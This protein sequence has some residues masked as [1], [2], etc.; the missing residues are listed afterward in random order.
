MLAR[1]PGPGLLG[2]WFTEQGLWKLRQQ[3]T[4]I[5]AESQEDHLEG[6]GGEWPLLA[7]SLQADFQRH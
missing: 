7:G 3:K 2:L 5:K 1:G 4:E 6:K